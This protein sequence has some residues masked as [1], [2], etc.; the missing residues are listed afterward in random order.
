MNMRTGDS[1][2]TPTDETGLSIYVENDVHATAG[3]DILGLAARTKTFCSSTEEPAL[4]PVWFSTGDC[5]GELATT[6]ARVATSA[7]TRADRVSAT[8]ASADAQRDC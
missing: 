3:G 2:A 5:T 6:R 1:D 7:Q 8:V 4:R